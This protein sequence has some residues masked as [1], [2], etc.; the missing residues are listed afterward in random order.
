MSMC[1]FFNF[2]QKHFIIVNAGSLEAHN[3]GFHRC[4]TRHMASCS[5]DCIAAVNTSSL[6]CAAD[7]V[8]QVHRCVQ[9][10][11]TQAPQDPVK[12]S[13]MTPRGTGV[14]LNS[15]A[16]CSNPVWSNS[17]SKGKQSKLWIP[18]WQQQDSAVVFSD[19]IV[20]W[21]KATSTRA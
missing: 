7:W 16:A 9:P 14:C 4:G 17:A 11:D 18:S 13:R 8:L 2:L 21:N 12:Y 19:A 5:E 1:I 10:K 6:H 3:L 20:D 15:E